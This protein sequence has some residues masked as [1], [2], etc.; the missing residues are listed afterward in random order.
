MVPISGLI[1]ALFTIYNWHNNGDNF[2][3]PVRSKHSSQSTTGTGTAITFGF[4]TGPV[5]RYIEALFA[6]YNWH[7][8][9]DNFWCRDGA[10]QPLYQS[11]LRT[12][13]PPGERRQLLV[14][15]RGP[16]AV[17]SKLSWGSTT[18]IGKTTSFV[19]K[20]GPIISQIKA[21]FVLYNRDGNGD[22]FLR[23]N[24]AG[25]SDVISKLSLR[26]TIANGM[27]T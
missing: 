6:I 2:W 16:S 8:N 9:G 10:R 14:S 25:P 3:C 20:T 22:N 26:S 21:L 24:G 27:V 4:V 7:G 12:L 1:E 23:R 18:Y 11:S 13:Q 15:K 5:S 17:R 19:V